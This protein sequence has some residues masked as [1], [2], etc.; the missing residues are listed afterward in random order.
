MLGWAGGV[1]NAKM[2]IKLFGRVRHVG[3]ERS[4]FWES[5]D[6]D[7]LLIGEFALITD[8]MDV[9]DAELHAHFDD[10]GGIFLVGGLEELNFV[11]SG[12]YKRVAGFQRCRCEKRKKR[13][14]FGYN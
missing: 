5:D 1:E 12:V 4:R 6:G 14:E 8:A 13:P 9:V 2:K 10:V 11:I 3:D 7:V